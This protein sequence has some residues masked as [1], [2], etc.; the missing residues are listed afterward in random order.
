MR[1]RRLLGAAALTTLV[2]ASLAGCVKM[3]MAL[4]LQ[5]DDTV[6]GTMIVAVSSALAELSGQDPDTIAEQL[7]GDSIDLEQGTITSQEP[8]D[9]GEYIGSTMTFEGETLDSFAGTSDGELGI[10][11]DGDDFVVSGTLDLSEAALGAGA[12]A[13]AT[14][15]TMMESIDIQISVTFPGEVSE[16]NGQLSGNTVTWTPNYGETLELSARGSAVEGG[17]GSDLPLG[18]LIGIGAAVLVAVGLIVFLVVRSRKSSAQP[19]AATA[20]YGAPAQPGY[21]APQQPA[22]PGYGQQPPAQPGYGQQ[23]PQVPPTA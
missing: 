15:A 17:G 6:D 10:V 9:D 20:A 18:L 5:A 13:D 16:H 1:T 2:A 22:Q 7:A 12:D 3:D 21:A 14:V 8:Y 11:R 19:A 23:P 4:E